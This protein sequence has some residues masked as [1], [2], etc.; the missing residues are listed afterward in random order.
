MKNI[1]AAT[2]LVAATSLPASAAKTIT[3][4]DIAFPVPAKVGDLPS[5]DFDYPSQVKIFSFRT[6][7]LLLIANDSSDPARTRLVI[8]AQRNKGA[9]TYTGQIVADYGGNELQLS[10]GPVSCSVK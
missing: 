3:C 1:V 4:G 9:R 2:L 7:N 10:N 6:E 5:I 8:S